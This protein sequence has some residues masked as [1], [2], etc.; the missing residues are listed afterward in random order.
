MNFD[1]DERQLL[2]RGNTLKHGLITMSFL[3]LLD[4]FLK[5]NG[6]FIVEGVWSSILIVVLVSVLCIHENILRDVL[7]IEE[8]FSNLWVLLFGIGG[9]ILL[10]WSII[11]IASGFVSVMIDGQLTREGVSLVMAICWSSLLFTYFYKKTELK[12][13]E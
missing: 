3:V 10:I 1:L 5:D 6:I 9:V 12:K 7:N 8:K 2:Q 13:T 11:D 4:A